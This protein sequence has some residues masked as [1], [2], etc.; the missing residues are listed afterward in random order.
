MRKNVVSLAD[1]NPMPQGGEWYTVLLRETKVRI[2]ILIEKEHFNLAKMASGHCLE[3][4]NFFA[5]IKVNHGEAKKL[6]IKE[7]K[8]VEN[9]I[10]KLSDARKKEN[11]KNILAM[12]KNF[13]EEHFV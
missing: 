9:A 10:N 1:L 13:Y 6:L 7:M 5:P 2:I 3:T 11:A 12:M 8:R 4:S